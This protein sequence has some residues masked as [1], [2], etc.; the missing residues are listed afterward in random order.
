MRHNTDGTIERS[1]GPTITGEMQINQSTMNRQ[2]S[3]VA[4]ATGPTPPISDNMHN[5]E[6]AAV[7]IQKIYNVAQ[8]NPE[9]R[10]TREE[11]SK[12]SRPKSAYRKRTEE[13]VAGSFTY[14]NSSQK[15]MLIQSQES[16][17][18]SQQLLQQ[19]RPSLS[20]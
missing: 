14:Q 5:L 13:G 3:M 17:R 19:N 4:Q 18:D 11:I 10:S 16:L 7:Q 15:K 20:N 6:K 12:N 2:A 8:M 1:R 9:S